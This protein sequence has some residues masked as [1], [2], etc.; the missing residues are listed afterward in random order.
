MTSNFVLNGAY[1][2]LSDRMVRNV[3]WKLK[4]NLWLI[5]SGLRKDL[6]AG[7]KVSKNTIGKVLRRAIIIYAYKKETF[8]EVYSCKKSSEIC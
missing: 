6:K 3:V 7:I 2:K 4:R 8:K 5:R 1:L